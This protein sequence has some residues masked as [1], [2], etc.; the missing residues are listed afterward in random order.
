M[1]TRLE[2]ASRETLSRIVDLCLDERV[3]AL[4]VAGDLFD[5]DTLKFSTEHY[6]VD[7][8]RRAIAAGVTVIAAT[9]NHDPGRAADRAAR[10]AWPAGFHLLKRR[11]PQAVEV[12]SAEGELCGMV[13]GAGHESPREGENLAAHFPKPSWDVP[14]IALLPDEAA[15]APLMG[16]GGGNQVSG[17]PGHQ[18]PRLHHALPRGPHEPSLDGAPPGRMDADHRVAV[19]REQTYGR[20][21]ARGNGAPGKRLQRIVVRRH[22]LGWTSGQNRSPA[23]KRHDMNGH[24]TTLG[25]GRHR[26]RLA[27]QE[28]H[29]PPLPG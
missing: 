5:N 2:Q 12:L 15:S 24:Q 10:I 9:G 19:D 11:E 4:L 26:G 18:L 21:Q 25:P 16:A 27:L 17:P 29:P 28:K 20:T 14:A 23:V 6:I 13:V 1:R 22:R 7:E 8:F 3:D